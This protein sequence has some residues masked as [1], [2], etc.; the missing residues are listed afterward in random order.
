LRPGARAL[1]RCNRA[2]A[3]RDRRP[4][5][6]QAQPAAKQHVNS[7]GNPATR[8]LAAGFR[9]APK[10][11]RAPDVRFRRPRSVRDTWEIPKSRIKIDRRTGA[12][13]K[14]ASP[15]S[16][17]GRAVRRE[18]KRG[19]H[20]GRLRVAGGA[21]RSAPEG[22]GRSFPLRLRGRFHDRFDNLLLAQRPRGRS[23]RRIEART[24]NS[25]GKTAAERELVLCVLAGHGAASPSDVHARDRCHSKCSSRQ[26]APRS[27]SRGSGAAAGAVEAVLRRIS[28]VHAP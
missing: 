1:R 16:D 5:A 24:T 19:R 22:R 9:G 13:K 21:D 12:P 14:R 8:W 7:G 3:T 15:S 11:I 10:E 20:R 2:G 6:H 27:T 4:N 23:S 25:Y 18:R 28:R 17:P 26:A